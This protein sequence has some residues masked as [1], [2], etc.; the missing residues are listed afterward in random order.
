[1][2]D[3]QGDSGIFPPFANGPQCAVHDG[4]KWVMV[5]GVD[6]AGTTSRDIWVLNLDSFQWRRSGEQ[7]PSDLNMQETCATHLDS[8]LFVADKQ[9]A[10]YNFPIANL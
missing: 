3:C 9:N 5:G 7:V 6:S 1:M 8:I 4:D 2:E 10:I